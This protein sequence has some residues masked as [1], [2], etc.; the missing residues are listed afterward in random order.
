[1][2]DISTNVGEGNKTA[3]GEPQRLVSGESRER[4]M[5]RYGGVQNMRVGQKA[6]NISANVA[7]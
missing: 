5:R 2:F 6:F 1:V 4:R 3:T 7:G